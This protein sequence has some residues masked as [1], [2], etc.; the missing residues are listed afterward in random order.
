MSDADIIEHWQQGAHDA[1]EMAQLAVQAG[2]FDHALFNCH[3]AIEKALKVLHMK[4]KQA[5]APWTH[6]LVYLSGLVDIDWSLQEKEL[7][8]ELSDMAVDA[9]YHDPLWAKEEAT[10]EN[11]EF[12]VTNVQ[13]FLSTHLK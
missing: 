7:L 8:Q 11:A 3:L 6:D 5:D 9:R 10:K 13:L 4:Q 12:W 2:K 1:L